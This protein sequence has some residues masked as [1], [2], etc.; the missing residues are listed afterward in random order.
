MTKKFEFKD[1]SDKN[2]VNKSEDHLEDNAI[3]NEAVTEHFK[4][5]LS[6]NDAISE[7]NNL[8][9][10]NGIQ[11]QKASIVAEGKNSEHGIEKSSNYERGFEEGK[12][13]EQEKIKKLSLDY[14]FLNKMKDLILSI[15]QNPDVSKEYMEHVIDII[16]ILVEKMKLHF[17]PDFSKILTEQLKLIFEKIHKS[18][19]L[20]IHVSKDREDYCKKLL[21]ENGFKDKMDKIIITIS[22]ELGENDIRIEHKN[23]RMEYNFDEISKDIDKIVHIFKNESKEQ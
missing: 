8:V 10:E 11:A 18:G 16:N 1:L 9:T 21:E 23:T 5:I 2:I 3:L 17:K 22:E 4:K 19:E 20:I 7:E 12:K 13:Q 6:D 15:E 14:E